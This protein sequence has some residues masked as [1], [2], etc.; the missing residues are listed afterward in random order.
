M[1]GGSQEVSDVYASFEMLYKVVRFT[2][3]AMFSGDLVKA[4]TVL[5]EA[6][7]LFVQLGNQKAIAVANNNLGSMFLGIYQKLEA[8]DLAVTAAVVS[9]QLL[10]VGSGEVVDQRVAVREGSA[11]LNAALARAHADLETMQPSEAPQY[12]TQLANRLF[13]RYLFLSSFPVF[14]S[15]I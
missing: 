5:S 14:R 9:G 3:A 6:K 12:Y 11:C 4:Y 13:N 8:G 15:P 10:D 2:N 1:A 7:S